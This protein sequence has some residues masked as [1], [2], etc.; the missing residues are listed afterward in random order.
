MGI[1][2]RN[3][4]DPPVGT[5]ST[6][7]VVG[8]EEMRVSTSLPG[9]RLP[10]SPKSDGHTIHSPIPSQVEG[11][12]LGLQVERGPPNWGLR[13]VVCLLPT[14]G[15]IYPVVDLDN[16]GDINIE[17]E[18]NNP[19]G[20]GSI[21]VVTIVLKSTVYPDERFNLCGNG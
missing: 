19:I 1:G 12:L 17:V 8:T 5:P 9:A 16:S 11:V 14:K 6:L 2:T 3:P 21:H 7:F 13:D 18:S 20:K 15:L 4:V 10:A